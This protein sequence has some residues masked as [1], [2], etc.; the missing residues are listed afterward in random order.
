MFSVP[1]VNIFP[2]ACFPVVKN[3][4]SKT[5]LTVKHTPTAAWI[6]FLR[7][8]VC[9]LEKGEKFIVPSPS[10]AQ[11]RLFKFFFSF[12]HRDSVS[13]SICDL[14]HTNKQKQ[15]WWGLTVLKLIS[16]DKLYKDKRGSEAGLFVFFPWL[17]TAPLPLST[18]SS[19]HTPSPDP[20][21]RG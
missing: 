20:P 2:A 9:E 13:S 12:T 7:T 21:L 6:F 16:W 19:P 11:P 5:Q 15:A 1:N 4:P 18:P 3:H 10:V 17:T 14:S 8:C